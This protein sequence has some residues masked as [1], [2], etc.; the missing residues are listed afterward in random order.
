MGLSIKN[1]LQ[2][3]QWLENLVFLWVKSKV[4]PK[5]LKTELSLDPKKP[6]C[7]VMSSRSFT[8]LLVL[9][10]HCQQHFLPRPVYLLK[11]LKRFGR[12]SYIYL[13]KPGILAKNR[14]KSLPVGLLRLVEHVLHENIDI[15]VVPVSVFWGRNPGKEE[16]SIFKLLFFDDEHSGLFQRF[17]TFFVQGR[18]VFCNFGKPLSVQ[19]LCEEKKDAFETTKKLRRILRIHFRKQRDTLVGPSIYDRRQVIES[20]VRSKPVKTFID[21]EAETKGKEREIIELQAKRYVDEIAANMSHPVIRF[22]DI[23]LTW[24]WRKIYSGVEVR[25]GEKVRELAQNYEI[26]YLPCHRSHMD[27]LLIGYTLYYLGLMTPHTAAGVNLNFWPIGSLLRRGGGFF[28]RR[29]FG[30]NKLYNIVFTEYVHFLIQS[31]YP[32]CF[33]PEGGRSRTGKLLHPKTGMLSMVVQS[34]QRNPDKPICLVPIYIGYDRL[35]E[36]KS[37]LHELKGLSKKSESFWQLLKARQILKSEFG[38]AYIVFGDAIDL[39][40]YLS[41]RNPNWKE[42]QSK[43]QDES[44]SLQSLSNE[45]MTRINQSIYLSYSSLFATAILALPKKAIVQEQFISLI[46]KWCDLLE[47]CCY[48]PNIH[49]P[50]N[51]YSNMLRYVESLSHIKRFEHPGGDVIYVNESDSVLLTY[52]RNMVLPLFCI[53]SIIAY[54][55]ENHPGISSQDLS[56]CGQELY[57]FLKQELFLP[58][59]TEECGELILKHASQMHS[60]NLVAFDHDQNLMPP[61]SSEDQFSLKILGHIADDFIEKI[62]ILFGLLGT[63]INKN[64]VSLETYEDEC[65]ALFQRVRLLAGHNEE[66][67]SSIFDP[68]IFRRFLDVL[69][70]TKLVTKQENHI[71]ISKALKTKADRIFIFINPELKYML[72][73]ALDIGK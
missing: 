61:Q 11:G 71:H 32:L 63:Y 23:L 34:L 54:F 66:S 48:H 70:Q 51:N 16:K 60:L 10:H 17:F 40:Q 8:D 14:D 31:S 44:K 30:G 52:Y 53:P 39:K 55:I 41:D 1:I 65:K 59:K 5:N 43:S 38:K 2:F 42:V 24:L 67:Q 4:I 46:S 26:I 21:H 35:M 56:H 50:K 33:Y 58:W 68:L 25:F 20:I 49:I 22:F 45:V 12:A 37:Y 7:Y 28:I 9:D 36:A 57:P 72:N 18:N 73:Q 27:Y 3:L 69:I 29:S 15:Q 47:L 6:V 62:T 19:A 13:A 64:Q